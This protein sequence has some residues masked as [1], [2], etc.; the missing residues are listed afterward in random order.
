MCDLLCSCTYSLVNDGRIMGILY[1][2]IICS[3]EEC[4]IIKDYVLDNE[5]KVKTIH[6][7]NDMVENTVTHRHH[8][9]TY[10]IFNGFE[11]P[12]E[13]ILLPKLEHIIRE[14]GYDKVPIK[15]QCW[16][17]IFRYNE[18]VQEH[19]HGDHGSTDDELFYLGGTLFISGPTHI[20]TYYE[21]EKFENEIGGLTLFTG[22]VKHHAP[23][24]TTNKDRI[25]IAFDVSPR[26]KNEEKFYNG[27]YERMKKEPPKLV[28]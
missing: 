7:Y 27:L 18:G 23:K 6:P 10:M 3:K 9:G 11:T 22:D 20:G 5:Y 12:I 4:N 21:G 8:S 26:R 1:N 24:N 28:S 17:N 14:L 25:T 2:S 15:V 16:V 19:S 13:D